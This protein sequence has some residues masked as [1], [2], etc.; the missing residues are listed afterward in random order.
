VD[1]NLTRPEKDIR[2]EGRWEFS[3]SL[4]SESMRNYYIGK[5]VKHYLPR[6]AENPI[7]YV[8]C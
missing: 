1:R 3:G 4:A 5:S 6:G 7:T 2:I 8:N